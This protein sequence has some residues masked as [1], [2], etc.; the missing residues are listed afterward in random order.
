M[1]VLVLHNA[2]AEQAGPEDRD[3]LVQ[4]RAVADALQGRGHAVRLAQLEEAEPEQALRRTLSPMPDLV[5]NLV[6]SCGGGAERAWQVPTLL[7][8]MGRALHQS[9]GKL[10]CKSLLGRFGLPTPHWLDLEA[11]LADAP[12]QPDTGAEYLLKSVWEHASQG[13]DAGGI[14]HARSGRDLLLPCLRRM[15]RHGGQWFA[16]AFVE[17]REFNLALLDAGDGTR[18]LPPAETVFHLAPGQR[19]IVDY[20]A[21][22]N[23]ESHAYHHTPRRFDF[24]LEDAALL[25]SLQ[26][27]ALACWHRLGLAGYARV[28][29]RV[30]RAGSPWIIDVN[31]N[32]CLA[33]DAGFA[34]AMERHGLDYARGV[35]AIA[36]A[37]LR[38][39]PARGAAAEA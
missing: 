35:E 15:S 29:F 32:P 24:P 13:L 20:D 34:A 28:D 6:E 12:A 8:A 10:V 31:A 18:V 2:V 27:L 23:P 9:T 3:T 14:V 11:M 5:F 22:W 37:A 33:P 38:R 36:L 1:N 7:D 21:K 4:A 39:C 30:D 16:E 25:Q 26:S 17:G 19:A